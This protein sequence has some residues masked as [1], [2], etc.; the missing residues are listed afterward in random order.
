M[1]PKGKDAK[2]GAVQGNYKAGKPLKDILPPNTKPP[3]EG[4][5]AKQEGEPEVDRKFEYEPLPHFPEWPGNEQAL[6]HDFSVGKTEEGDEKQYEDN[7]KIHL[8]PSFAEFQRD[9]NI[10]CR[11]GEYITEILHEKAINELKAEKRRQSKTR[12]NVRKQA[13]L[14]MGE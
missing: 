3:R 13:M 1:P 14:A 2:K 9:T 10:W 12:K 7:A 5:I 8:P 4:V 11:P 6:G